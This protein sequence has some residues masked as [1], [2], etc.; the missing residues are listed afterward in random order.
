MFIKTNIYYMRYIKLFENYDIN[1]I[2]ENLWEYVSKFYVDKITF[3]KNFINDSDKDLVVEISAK[4]KFAYTKYK[5]FIPYITDDEGNLASTSDVK[6][7]LLMAL[8][9]KFPRIEINGIIFED[10]IS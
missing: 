10:R 3:G 6:K 7:S 1:S 5:Y 2:E 8:S 9:K 4:G